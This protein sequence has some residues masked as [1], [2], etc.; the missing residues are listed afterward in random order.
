MGGSFS[1]LDTT[2]DLT[3]IATALTPGLTYEFKI[4]ARNQYDF[5]EYSETLTLL[6]SFIPEIPTTVVTSIETNQVKIAWVLPSSNG[7]PITEYKV[8]I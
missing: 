4:E 6:C 3:Y 2:S 5:S 1:V 8:F 7:S